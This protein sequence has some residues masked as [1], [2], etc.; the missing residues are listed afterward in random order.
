MLVLKLQCDV[1][2]KSLTEITREQADKII[3]GY[4]EDEASIFK[5]F[6]DTISGI[7]NITYPLTTPDVVVI[8]SVDSIG[9]LLWDIA[10]GY[11]RI[12]DDETETTKQSVISQEER[13]QLLNRNKTN[14]I[15]GIYGHD[16]SD[17]VF[18]G[19]ELMD[20]G[21]IEILVGS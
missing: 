15:H 1:H 19:I 10:Q 4:D 16:L 17:L 11:K 18:E 3:I 13:G 8:K 12:Y 7:V 2:I 21:I 5:Y 9:E 20:D 6:D 14:G